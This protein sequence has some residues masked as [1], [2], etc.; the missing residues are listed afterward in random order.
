MIIE[1]RNLLLKLPYVS[2]Q[3]IR[4]SQ[5]NNAI[6][7][8][9]KMH[10]YFVPVLNTNKKYYHFGSRVSSLTLLSFLEQAERLLPLPH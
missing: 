4:L 6:E 1:Y 3:E 2:L 5:A 8:D 9:D 7:Y 10:A